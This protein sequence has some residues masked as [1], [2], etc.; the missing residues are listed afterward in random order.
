MPILEIVEILRPAEQGRNK[1]FLCRGEDEQLYYVKGQNAGRNRQ[2]CE[3]VAGNLAKAFG[4]P[5]PEFRLVTIPKSLLRDAPSEFQ[6]IGVGIAFASEEQRV[7]HWFERS[8]VRKVPKQLRLDVLVFDWWVKNDDRLQDNPNLLW[9]QQSQ[10]L[11]VID[12]DS[13]F[14]RDFFPTGFRNYHIFHE[15]WESV[16]GDLVCQAEYA[17][18][19]SAALSIWKFTCD[20]IPK[21]W[22]PPLGMEDGTFDPME[23]YKILTR[24]LTTEIWREG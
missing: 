14:S 13:A 21:E 15:D 19:M 1:A 16:F 8:Y 9:D 10:R 22:V 18:R 6:Q 7:S 17:S 5:I 12:H 3:W 20:N 2:C 23:A 11:H 4:L 24:C